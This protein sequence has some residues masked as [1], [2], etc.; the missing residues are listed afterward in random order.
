LACSKLAVE[1]ISEF[2]LKQELIFASKTSA[3][4]T[5]SLS[6]SFESFG[7]P[8]QAKQLLH[9]KS[10]LLKIQDFKKKIQSLRFWFFKKV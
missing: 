3:A 5:L 2:V 4:L 8:F 6:P 1:E 9:V 10:S 7:I